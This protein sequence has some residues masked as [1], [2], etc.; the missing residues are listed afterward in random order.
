[1]HSFQPAISAFAKITTFLFITLGLLALPAAVAAHSLPSSN[2]AT[3]CSAAIN[4]GDTLLCSLSTPSEVNSFSFTANPN[5][6]IIVRMGRRTSGLNPHV[7]VLGPGGT[8]ICQAYS[9]SAAIDIPACLLDSGGS[10]TILASNYASTATGSYALSLQRLNNPATATTLSFGQTQLATIAVAAEFGTYTFTGISNDKVLV[11]MGS[12]GS[13]LTPHLRLYKPDG[14]SLCENYSYSAALDLA[15]CILP[16]SGQYTLVVSDYAGVD[17][18]GYGVIVQRLNSPGNTSPLAFGQTTLATISAPGEVDT[19]SFTAAAADTLVVRMGSASSVLAPH[20]RMYGPDGVKLCET[21]SYSP[22]IDT[23]GCLAPSNGAYKVLVNDYNGADSGSYG[24]SLQRV[25]NPSQPQALAFGQLQTTDLIA[26][27]QLA[28]YT[29]AANS[30][31]T[32]LLRMGGTSNGIYP[33]MRVFAANGTMICNANGYPSAVEIPGCILPSAG[34]FSVLVNDYNH[35]TTGSY[36]LTL[37]RLNNPGNATSLLINQIA[38]D[39]ISAP[40]Q[41]A[42]YTF[43]TK[44]NSTVRVRMSSPYGGVYPSIR[45]YGPDGVLLCQASGYYGVVE[46]DR[47]VLPSDSTYTVVAAN[48]NGAGSGNYYLSV[49]CLG[50][51]C[52]PALQLSYVYLPLT[53]R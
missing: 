2:A 28:T 30:G 20:I 19:Y 25:N 6:R 4:F 51:D 41:F 48:Y 52:G 49:L 42:T 12:S 5:D 27:G 23:G 50:G 17:T 14:T 39:A 18:G 46:T 45:L 24:I 11:R 40:G 13:G 1:M 34:V 22:A 29:F 43:A 16:T 21:Y 7:Q 15:P 47:C 37:Q 8:Q 26:P 32:V 36:G 3:G 10:Y 44:A 33:Q 9:Y 38:T 31:D 35:S 53:R